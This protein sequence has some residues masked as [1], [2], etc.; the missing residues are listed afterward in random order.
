[1][2]WLGRDQRVTA[3]LAQVRGHLLRSCTVQ[4]V[5]AFYDLGW[6]TVKSID[7]ARLREPVVEPDWPTIPYPTMDEHPAQ[8]TSLRHS[9]RR[10]DR[11]AS[12][13][14]RKG[15]LA[16]DCPSVLRATLTGRGQARRGSRPST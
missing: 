11:T 16:R 15:P 12:V 1:M 9:G 6:H 14:D 3:R 13:L 2:E 5:G 4:A 7:K 10:S 8:G